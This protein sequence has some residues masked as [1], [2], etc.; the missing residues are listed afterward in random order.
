MAGNVGRADTIRKNN[1]VIVGVQDKRIS[2][3]GESIDVTSDEDVGVRKLLE[4][5]GQQQ[6]SISISGVF[7]DP[8]FRAIALNSSTSGHL[9]DITYHFA[10]GSSIAGDVLLV[11]YDDGGPYND[12]TTFSV[13]LEYSNTWTLVPA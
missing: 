7:K 2:W 4:D 3:S 11:G 12:A 13:T 9:T 8:T 5:Y 10:D 6:L 1:V